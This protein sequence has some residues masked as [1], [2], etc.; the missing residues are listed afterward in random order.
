MN[1]PLYIATTAKGEVYEFF[2]DEEF[3]EWAKTAPKHKA[4]R[5]KGLGGFDTETFSRFLENRDRYLTRI[6]ALEAED[7]AKF[8]LAFSNTEQDSRKLWLDGVQYFAEID[9]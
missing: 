3:E 1:T 5:F 2:T 7:L 4:D 6:T 9:K 8:E